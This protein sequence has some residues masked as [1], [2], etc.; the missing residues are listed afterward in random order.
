MNQYEAIQNFSDE[1]PSNNLNSHDHEEIQTIHPLSKLYS[2]IIDKFVPST[3]IH[4][5]Q[6]NELEQKGITFMIQGSFFSI[7]TVEILPDGV[8]PWEN[9]LCIEL[10]TNKIEFYKNGSCIIEEYLDASDIERKFTLDH[11]IN[12]F[13]SIDNLF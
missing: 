5:E 6:L 2:S 1:E 12:L 10:E 9:E 11:V 4:L 7:K 13:R 8:E 3:S